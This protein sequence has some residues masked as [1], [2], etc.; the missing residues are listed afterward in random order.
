MAPERASIPNS[1]EFFEA[2]FDQSPV[3]HFVVDRNTLRF[4]A[5]NEAT[6]ARYGY[7]REEF[8]E[9]DIYAIR[10]SEERERLRRSL[11]SGGVAPRRRELWTHQSKS[12]ERFYVE[13]TTHRIAYE[14]REAVLVAAVDVNERVLAGRE[15]EASQKHFQRLANHAPVLIWLSDPQGNCTF[16]N[17]E[18]LSWRGVDVAEEMA[19]AWKRD[20]HPEDLDRCQSVVGAAFTRG[21]A[22]TIEYRMRNRTREYRWLLE[23]ARPL[24]AAD[25][26]VESYLGTCTDVTPLKETERELAR[27]REFFQTMLDRVP[28]M[29]IAEADGGELLF[30]NRELERVLGWTA[31]EIR[32][33]G[34][35]GESLSTFLYPDPEE[36]LRAIEFSRRGSTDWGEF[37]PRVRDGRTIDMVWAT[38]RLSDGTL[39]GIGQDVTTR[40]RLTDELRQAQRMESVGRL[41]GGIAHDFNNLLTALLGYTDIAVKR[42]AGNPAALESLEEIRKAGERAA[43]LTGRLLAFS[44]KQ[45]VTPRLLDL[46]GVVR[47]LTG[48]LRR[49]IGEDIVLEMSI[50]VGTPLVRADK[51]QME[52]MLLNL[53]VNARDAMPRGGSLRIELRAA[54]PSPD[55]GAP[56]GPGSG[57]VLLLVRDSGEG[58]SPDV[59]A[60]IFEPFY[61]TK[62]LGEGT[63]LGLATVYGIVRQAGATIEVESAPGAG[64]EFRILFPA[65]EGDVEDEPPPPEA[66]FGDGTETILLVEDDTAVRELTVEMLQ[67]GGYKVVAAANGRD[68]IVLLE[69]GIHVDLMISDLVM[70]GLNGWQVRE[71][72]GQTHPELPFIFMSGYAA[73]DIARRG[74]QTEGA[75]F[76]AKPFRNEDLLHRVRTLL[77]RSQAARP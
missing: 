6:V 48:M 4:L 16:M 35:K 46:G 34:A 51:A 65:A 8:R 43:A 67:L 15:L 49:L 76:L 39:V 21:S 5:V 50:E 52:Q 41:A 72:V 13:I 71:L 12:G 69:R 14:G 64:S 54:D 75:A 61:T 45:V 17:G 56:A 47:G 68:A 74:I 10:P 31:D 7:T 19:G 9:I 73:D 36:R 28:V 22:Y 63:G 37:R 30:A 20:I 24:H 18:W 59:K 70:P 26:R 11:T 60:H 44:R 58:M 57:R 42:A 40:N 62:P 29:I 55:A 3:P 25:G 38:V 2:L 66:V 27:Q 53:V 32:T 1:A 33:L 77:D 23:H